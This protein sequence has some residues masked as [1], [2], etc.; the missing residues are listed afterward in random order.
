MVSLA[1][2]RLKD[3]L[4][5]GT[6]NSTE[7]LLSEAEFGDRHKMTDDTSS[8]TIVHSACQHD[9]PDNCAMETVV[10]DGKVISV[11]G[12]RDHPFTRGVLCAKVKS[13]DKRVY[14]ADRILH[15]L[16]RIGAKGEGRFERISWNQALDTIRD[17]FKAIIAG[18][19]AE[20][21]LPYSYLGTQG[22]LN[23]MHCGDPFFN[24]LGATIAERS[25]CNSG[26]SKAFR[27]V[28]GPTGGLDPE[29]FAHA[30]LII[31]WG[32]N[33]VSTSMHHWRFI[34][35]AVQNGA[36]L[37]VIDPLRSRTAARADVHIR[38]RPGTDA[39]LALALIHQIVENGACDQDYVDQYT[40]GFEELRARAADYPPQIAAAITGIP[41]ADILELATLYASTQPSAIRTGVALERTRNGP[42][43]VRAIACLPALTGAWRLVGGGM[44]QHPQGSLPVR[45]DRLTRPDFVQEGR[46]TVNLFGLSEALEPDSDRPVRALF[47]YNANPITASADQNGIVRGLKREDLFTVVSEI[48]PT[49][50]TDYADIVLPATSQLEQRD[51]MYSW[52]HFNLQLNQPAIAP[53]GEA[54]S[55]TELFRRLARHMGFDEAD[56]FRSDEVLVADSLDWQAEQLKG[57]GLDRLHEEG[58]VRLN[59]G[60]PDSRCPHAEGNFPTPSGK[61][62]FVS[63][64][65]ETG[66]TM[67]EV[68]RQGFTGSEPGG[69][70]DPLPGHVPL[71]SSGSYPLAL[72]SPKTHHLLNSGYA[73]LSHASPTRGSAGNMEMQPVWLHPRDAELKSIGDGDQVRVFNEL[74]EI[75]CRS[76]LTEDTLPGVVMVPHGYWRKHVNGATVNALVRHAPNDIGRSP[77]INDAR[78]DVALI[79]ARV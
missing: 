19:G 67:L 58:F 70:V 38:P 42:D 60:E 53:L 33:V 15:P 22:L 35:N 17:R 49:D 2:V 14:A 65:A 59:V 32:I 3:I 45:R 24:R 63:S 75:I 21:I 76:V 7:Y 66:G 13:F 51:L 10:R 43:A 12:R 34:K 73:N 69:A 6:E 37:V 25:F 55:N 11:A 77:S 64:V 29:S 68:Y 71:A 23:G 79:P 52:G 57:A 50:S 74:G 72:I 48:F 27:M 8:D 20:A 9:C 18:D 28:C 62:E 31:L 46:R 40:L 30:K 41:E 44:F 78:V 54:V 1:Y 5:V 56:L 4:E 36:K 39:A 61:C 26:A 47:V 16:R